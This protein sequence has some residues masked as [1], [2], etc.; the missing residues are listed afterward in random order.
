MQRAPGQPLCAHGVQCYRNNPL[1][2]EEFDH[3]ADHP[4]LKRTAEE[5][6]PSG[7][8]AK[9]AKGAKGAKEADDPPPAQ[10]AEEASSSSSSPPPSSPAV[11]VFAPGASGLT[12]Q[13]M[14]LFQ[15]GL[16]TSLGLIVS[17]C[18]DNALAKGEARWTC[19]QV[20]SS[21]NLRHLLAVV[22]RAA[23]AHPGCK[24]FLAGASFGNRVAAEALRTHSDELLKL[25]VQ[26]AL[27]SCGYPLISPGK[28][29]I[30]EPG[31]DAKRPA[32]LLNLPASV[33][34]LLLQ[35]T[36]DEY[37]GPRGI[38]ALEEL[39]P[40]M[41]ATAELVEVPNGTHGLPTATRL[42]ELGKKQADVDQGIG[43]AILEFVSRF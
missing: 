3:P 34:V 13:K 19:Q 20:G 42:K 27:I 37:N 39:I 38:T 4:K 2:W 9:K 33:R 36:A 7:P 23:A 12:A 26:P 8:P 29:D 16:L 11:L 15:D 31:Y 30:G 40:A 1:H 32:S 35:G 14:R 41:S 25:G 22:G 24:I 5:G 18:D 6:S 21:S 10:E 28:P 43:K 17:R